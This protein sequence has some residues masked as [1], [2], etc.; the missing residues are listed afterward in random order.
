MTDCD[1]TSKMADSGPSKS[2]IEAIF[3]RL[4][5]IP[6]N[7]VCYYSRNMLSVNRFSVTVFYCVSVYRFVSTAMRRI[8]RGHR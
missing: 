5:A 3:Q 4:R 7:K 2:D 1:N 6:A 8:L